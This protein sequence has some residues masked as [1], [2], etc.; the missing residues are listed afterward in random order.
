ME[1]QLILQLK[2]QQRNHLKIE[3]KDLQRKEKFKL[4]NL[5]KK[6]KKN[7]KKELKKKNNN[8]QHLKMFQEEL[9]Q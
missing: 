2:T 6:E 5:L 8:N 3:I 4:K 7:K 1:E 9:L